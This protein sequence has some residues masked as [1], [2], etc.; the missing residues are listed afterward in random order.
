MADNGRRDGTQGLNRTA[1]GSLECV[2][3]VEGLGSAVQSVL[4]RILVPVSVDSE[5]QS[6]GTCHHQRLTGLRLGVNMRCLS[7]P[8]IY[9]IG[10][11]VQHCPFRD[12]NE[13]R[14]KCSLSF[15]TRTLT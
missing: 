10:Y 7:A 9:L 12:I 11:S 8:I 3:E 14:P 1:D 6:V 2:R 4:V 5:R 15:A 13:E